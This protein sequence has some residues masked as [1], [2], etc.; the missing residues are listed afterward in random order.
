M[1]FCFF[2]LIA[3]VLWEITVNYLWTPTISKKNI[4]RSYIHLV[5]LKTLR[6]NGRK[7]AKKFVE[8]GKSDCQ[9]RSHNHNW[10][11]CRRTPVTRMK[12]SCGW[13]RK[14][15]S[16]LLSLI[17]RIN[18]FAS[19]TRASPVVNRIAESRIGRSKSFGISFSSKP[20]V[21]LTKKHKLLIFATASKLTNKISS[22]KNSTTIYFIVKLTTTSPK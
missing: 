14:S 11:T 6:M 10:W 21:L 17:V 1:I 5:L 8:I 4:R 13:S 2:F 12:L 20:R 7:R 18:R 19:S 9:L 3:D 22:C 16:A 15:P